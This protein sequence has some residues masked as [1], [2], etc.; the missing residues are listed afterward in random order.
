MQDLCLIVK[1]VILLIGPKLKLI[2]I[3]DLTMITTHTF[4]TCVTLE[5]FNQVVFTSIF[6]AL[7][8]LLS[9]QAGRNV[10]LVKYLY[11]SKPWT[12]PAGWIEVIHYP[13]PW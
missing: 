9:Q 8:F 4:A 2:I 6:S 13:R 1:C 10:V 12:L 11:S 7:L 3:Q 5:Q